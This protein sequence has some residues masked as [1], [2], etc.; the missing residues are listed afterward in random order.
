MAQGKSEEE[1]VDNIR[2]A[3]RGYLIVAREKRRAIP[4]EEIRLVEVS[5]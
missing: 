5:L 2:E 4:A 1:V 3:I